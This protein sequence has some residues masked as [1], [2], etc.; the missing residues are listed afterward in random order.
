MTVPIP[1]RPT[2][3]GPPDP[4]A[5]VRVALACLDT[6]DITSPADHVAVFEEVHAALSDALA[7]DAIE[8]R[9]A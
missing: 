3:L 4:A 5:R 9:R 1:P 8:P 2:G 7:A 6:L